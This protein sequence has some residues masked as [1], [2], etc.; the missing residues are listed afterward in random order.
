MTY[1]LKEHMAKL[2]SYILKKELYNL[3]DRVSLHHKYDLNKG[4]FFYQINTN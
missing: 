1:I 3:I 4:N 2:S